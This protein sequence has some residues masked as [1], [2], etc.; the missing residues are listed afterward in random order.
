MYKD[1]YLSVVLNYTTENETVKTILNR[2]L[3]KCYKPS[4]VRP[5]CL[6]SS[7]NPS[8]KLG[9]AV[10]PGRIVEIDISNASDGY[11]LKKSH[12]YGAFW[13]QMSYLDLFP[14]RETHQHSGLEV[15]FKGECDLRR[16]L[17]EITQ[18]EIEEMRPKLIVHAN[19]D[20]MYYWGIKKNSPIKEDANDEENPWMGYRFR[21]VVP[22]KYRGLPDCM[23]KDGRMELF[24]LYEVVGFVDNE[25]RV[26]QKNYPKDTALE[27]SFLMEYV[28]DGRNK[29]YNGKLYKESEWLEIWAWVNKQ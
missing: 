11:W 5:C 24:P 9:D 10:F 20:S 4:Q 25:N 1:D 18:R 23:L 19:K 13:R 7:I 14:I 17:L 2:G 26:G 3:V 16:D 28:M 12:Q 6:L 29:K 21:R 8:F 15:S 22:E 27:G